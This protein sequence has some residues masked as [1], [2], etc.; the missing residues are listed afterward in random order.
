MFYQIVKKIA[1]IAIK[2]YCRD[3]KIDQKFC[4][5]NKGPLLLAVNHPNSFLDAI[6][7]CTLFDEPVYSL[8]RGDA[9]NGKLITAFLRSLKMLPVYRVSEGVEN[10]EGNYTTFSACIELFKK[11]G[12]VLIFTEGKSENE[13]HL[14]PLKK[15]TA[16]LALTAW[17][18]N[19]PLK[20]LPIGLNYNSFFLFGKN[21]H[22]NIG[23]YIESGIMKN[24]DG[25]N[26]R[27]LNNITG[28]IQQQLQQGVYEIDSTD[29]QKKRSVFSVKF[30][31]IKTALLFVPCFAGFPLHWPFYFILKKLIVKKAAMLGH[32]DSIIVGVLLIFYPF[33]I[34][35]WALVAQFFLGGY[36]G[37]IIAAAVPICGWC[38]MQLN[39]QID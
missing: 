29:R 31:K 10:L 5:K 37:I 28:A 26:G 19:I 22:I 12:I 24:A 1:R 21:V 34:L 27:Q 30:N 13:W 3:I 8:A 17:Q 25:E 2:F 15:G 36:W 39:R 4:L 23:E 20:I 32:F 7:L 18:Q 9:F 38:C 6:I 14:R 16:R 35:F 33:L 11:G